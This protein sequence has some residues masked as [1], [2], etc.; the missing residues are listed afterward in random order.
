MTKAQRAYN[1]T[2]IEIAQTKSDTARGTWTV[3]QTTSNPL[4][5]TRSRRVLLKDQ[6]SLE[7]AKDAA[8]DVSRGYPIRV[9]Y[10]GV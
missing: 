8:L 1:E 10:S 4:M 7:A 2:R 9:T 6:P 3:Y 5:A